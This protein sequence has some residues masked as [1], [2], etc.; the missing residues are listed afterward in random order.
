[1]GICCATK[2]TFAACVKAPLAV[3]EVEVFWADLAM[4]TAC[5]YTNNTII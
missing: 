5:L 4:V 1:M 3:S 2:A